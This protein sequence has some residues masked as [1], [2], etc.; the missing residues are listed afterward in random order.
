MATSYLTF[1]N[2]G[3]GSQPFGSASGI[4]MIDNFSSTDLPYS[5]VSN[6]AV[7]TDPY[8]N[9]AFYKIGL[10]YMTVGGTSGTTNAARM[11]LW[12]NATTIFDYANITLNGTAAT[13]SSATAN[14]S[15]SVNAVI[16]NSTTYYMGTWASASLAAKRDTATG[17]FS[18]YT[19]NASSG[20]VGTTYNPGNLQFG[21]RYTY[22]PT[23]PQSFTATANTSSSVDLS[24]TAPSDPGGYLASTLR[25]KIKWTAS[26]SGKTGSVE[27]TAANT[28][29]YTVTGL[30]PGETYT[31]TV[32]AMNDVVPTTGNSYSSTDG[33]VFIDWYSSGPVA[34]ASVQLKGGVW[35]GSV[36]KPYTRVVRFFQPPISF[37]SGNVSTFSSQA[38][39]TVN[40]ATQ[41]FAVG[42]T[43][44]IANTTG[45]SGFN[46]TWLVFGVGG[47]ANAWTVSFTQ[48][49]FNA[50]PTVAN[51]TTQGTIT[52]YYPTVLKQYNASNVSWTDIYTS[53]TS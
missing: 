10:V 28:L 41:P 35:N 50:S 42:H 45:L 16:A 11:G 23:A 8:Q 26:N 4:K 12:S 9:I 40:T 36:W 52:G 34:T 19:G 27:E 39:L 24:W 18:S 29:S 30:V 37:T 49:Y 22:L 21:M 13:V 17:S 3:T 51:L 38:T 31:F 47:S 7:H 32:A 46:G 53:P 2:G 43:V 48:G 20:T 25:Y 6:A 44:V 33:S 5:P 14:T 15:V 1:T